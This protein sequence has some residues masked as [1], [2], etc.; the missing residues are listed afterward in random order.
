MCDPRTIL[1]MKTFDP[2]TISFFDTLNSQNQEI[3]VGS[4]RFF[5]DKNVW[6]VHEI[7]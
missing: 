7:D 5:Q 1:S 6:R 2:R 4:E 3:R